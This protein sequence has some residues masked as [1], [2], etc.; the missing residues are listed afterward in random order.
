MDTIGSLEPE[1][2]QPVSLGNTSPARG[3]HLFPPNA[4]IGLLTPVIPSNN[5]RGGKPIN[6]Q[7]LTLS[8]TDGNFASTSPLTA[9]PASTSWADGPKSSFSRTQLSPSVRKFMGEKENRRLRPEPIRIPLTSPGMRASSYCSA[10]TARPDLGRAHS[11]T[12]L[13]IADAP[14]SASRRGSV[15]LPRTPHTPSPE[16]GSR[17]AMPLTARRIGVGEV[18]HRDRH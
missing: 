3:G 6:L 7:M 16:A 5:I 8:P 9:S 1:V 2:R 15:P 4:D 12:L 14:T 13:S 11:L 17:T 18:G 10:I